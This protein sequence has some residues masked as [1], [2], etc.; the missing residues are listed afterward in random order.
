MTASLITIDGHRLDRAPSFQHASAERKAALRQLGAALKQ[1]GYAFTT[2]T[3]LTHKRVNARFASGW[4]HDLA[5]IFGW[6]RPL[7][8]R[9]KLPKMALL[10]CW[11]Q[12]EHLK[13]R[14]L[15][16]C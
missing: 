12:L 3:P 2:V 7:N 14:S 10:A 13:A 6:S 8:P 4:A 11:R 16:V 9:L 15:Q 5:G 1:H